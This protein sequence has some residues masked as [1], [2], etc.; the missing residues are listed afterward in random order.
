[1]DSV[2]QKERD[3]KCNYIIWTNHLQKNLK[4]IG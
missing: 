3:T 1:M 2:D 4:M